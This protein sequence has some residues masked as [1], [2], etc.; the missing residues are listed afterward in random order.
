MGRGTRAPGSPSS[1]RSR[2]PS[3]A[4]PLCPRL[5]LCPRAR[6][7][8]SQLCLELTFGTSAEWAELPAWR[9]RIRVT[10]FALLLPLY[11]CL[12]LGVPLADP[13]TYSQQWLVVS[14]LCRCA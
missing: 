9:R 4:Q 5:T 14:M 8:P 3:T 1:G 7:A 2:P 11:L 6:P 12:R 13:E 10:S